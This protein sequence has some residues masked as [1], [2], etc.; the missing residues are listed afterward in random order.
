MLPNVICLCQSQKTGTVFFQWYIYKRI[1]N[2]KGC[3]YIYSLL[4]FCWADA[5]YSNK[6]PDNFKSWQ[7]SWV[8]CTRVIKIVWP[9][10][11]YTMGRQSKM[12]TT[13]QKW[14][15]IF[16]LAW[17]CLCDIANHIWCNITVKTSCRLSKNSVKKMNWS[18]SLLWLTLNSLRW[19]DTYMRW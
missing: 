15:N 2:W 13:W 10:N 9:L 16:S 5:F 12:H 17:F 6:N 3:D 19:S 4:I 8:L 7:L 11:R 18:R 1:S 14:W